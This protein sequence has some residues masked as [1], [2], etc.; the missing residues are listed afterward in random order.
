[1]ARSTNEIVPFVAERETTGALRE[2]RVGV[3]VGMVVSCWVCGRMVEEIG[4]ITWK[5]SIVG[6][7]IIEGRGSV[8]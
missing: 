2:S 8:V 7:E 5:I 6:E 3:L 1:M 4:G